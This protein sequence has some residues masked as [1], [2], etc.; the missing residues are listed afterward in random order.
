MGTTYTEFVKEWAKRNGVTYMCAIGKQGLK[1]D[2]KKSKQIVN[3]KGR[4]VE[5][6]N[7]YNEQGGFRPRAKRTRK[8]KEKAPELKRR[9]TIELEQPIQLGLASM[10]A[11]KQNTEEIKRKADFKA[12]LSRTPKKRETKIIVKSGDAVK[13]RKAKEARNRE[14]MGKEDINMVR[15]ESSVRIIPQKQRTGVRMKFQKPLRISNLP[16]NWIQQRSGDGTG[17]R[18]VFFNTMTGRSQFEIPR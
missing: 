2:Y 14:D 6:V 3:K 16:P 7:S 8:P 18:T 5:A 13:V 4:A 17:E 1:D 11:K 10:L 12:Q 15:K 9:N